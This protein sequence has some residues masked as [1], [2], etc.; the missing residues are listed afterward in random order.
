MLRNYFVI[1]IVLIVIIAV[2]GLKLYKVI[3]YSIEIPAE[4]GVKHPREESVDIKR[5]NN[6]LKGKSFQVISE[7]DLFRPSRTPVLS[8]DTSKPQTPKNPPKL[9]GTILLNNK[10]TAILEDPETKTTRNYHIND[11]VAGYVIADILEDKVVFF[12]DGDKVEVRLRDNKGVKPSRRPKYK[13]PTGQEKQ[14]RVPKRPV[15]RAPRRRTIEQNKSQL[16][17]LP[18]EIEE[19]MKNME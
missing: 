4:A 13:P 1:N 15:R 16:E 14:K 5:A 8:T 7:M 10:K 18:E 17:N 3:A 6:N 11:S 12:T 19:L 2:L 9:F